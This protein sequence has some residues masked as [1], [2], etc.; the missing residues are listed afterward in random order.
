[1][2]MRL[3]VNQPD[4]QQLITLG[5]ARTGFRRL[6]RRSTRAISAATVAKASKGKAG[7]MPA[8]TR[9]R[10]PHEGEPEHPTG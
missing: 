8:L 6:R 5:F 3:L 9:N 4:R 10:M 2:P 1:M 7:E